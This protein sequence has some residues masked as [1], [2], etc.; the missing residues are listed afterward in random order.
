M[1]CSFGDWP[2]QHV[3]RR[4]IDWNAEKV[5]EAIFKADHSKQ[6]QVLGG[7]KVRNQI[8]IG[9]LG[10]GTRHGPM[11]AQMDDSG[12]FQFRLMLAQS[13]NDMLSIHTGLSHICSRP[14]RILSYFLAYDL[15]KIL[16]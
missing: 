11:Q 12:G 10:F 1:C 6:G 14:A 16:R 15:G 9:C 5:G 7:V 2:L 13:G 3:R 8:D 4:E